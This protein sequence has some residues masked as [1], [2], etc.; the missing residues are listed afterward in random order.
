MN[1]KKQAVD[2]AAVGYPGFQVRCP[3]DL[4]LTPVALKRIALAKLSDVTMLSASFGE[5]RFLFLPWLTILI[6]CGTSMQLIG[7]YRTDESEPAENSAEFFRVPRV[8]L[9]KSEWNLSFDLQQDLNTENLRQY[10]SYGPQIKHTWVFANRATHPTIDDVMS[11]VLSVLTQGISVTPVGP[12]DPEW[13]YI[14]V[15]LADDKLNCKINYSPLLAQSESVE[16]ALPSWMDSMNE[17]LQKEGL[18]P[19]GEIDISIKRSVPEMIST[20]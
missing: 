12:R 18:P 16:T 5:E 14:E 10:L 8:C 15:D 9:R 19:D 6:N 7:A 20:M 4:K 11:S 17:L 1:A 3:P 13:K 2:P